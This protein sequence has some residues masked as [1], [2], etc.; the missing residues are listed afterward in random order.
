MLFLESLKW[1]S[2][3]RALLWLLLWQLSFVI[4]YNKPFWHET[5]GSYLVEYLNDER[6][7]CKDTENYF[8]ANGGNIY[9]YS[10]EDGKRAVCVSLEGEEKKIEDFAVWED[11]IYYVTTMRNEENELIWEM[12][13][14]D[15]QSKEQEILLINEDFIRLNGE[16]KVDSAGVDAHNG[17]LFFE[18]NGDK[19][20]LCPIDENVN[21]NSIDLQSL[22]ASETSYEKIQQVEYDGIILERE[23]RSQGRYDITGIWDEQG[24]KILYSGVENRIAVGDV[25]VRFREIRNTYG[26]HQFQYQ[27]ETDD[28]W[29]RRWKNIS[30]FNKEK[31]ATSYISGDYMWIEDDRIVG[32]MVVP[33]GGGRKVHKG[34][35]QYFLK[36]N[37]L[38]ELDTETGKGRILFDTR[39]NRTTIIGYKEKD[40]YYIK[41]EKVYVKNL[42]TKEKTVLGDIPKE[43]DYIIDWQGGYLIIREDFTYGQNGDMVLVYNVR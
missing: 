24:Y 20:Y 33:D 40:L 37:I 1:I 7:R 21:T 38:Y 14:I 35:S 27:M 31:Y 11:D 9:R 42:E 34:F 2:I 4:G 30:V 13:R 5:E 32:L 25:W 43:K 3:I 28:L 23:E 16:E 6:N 17:Y 18:F 41:N 36:K 39:T 19:E 29:M 15:C 10:F 26:N 12:C 22:F 8:F